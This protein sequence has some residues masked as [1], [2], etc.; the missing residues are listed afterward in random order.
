M[1]QHRTD[2]TPASFR[3]RALPAACLLSLAVGSACGAAG[4]TIRI[5][6][7][8]NQLPA[9]PVS[10]RAPEG[11]DPKAG[12]VLSCAGKEIPA[13]LD[14]DGRLWFWSEGIEAGKS[15][16]CQLTKADRSRIPDRVVLKDAGEGLIEVTIDGKPFTALNFRPTEPRV[17]LYPLLA[18]TGDPVTRDWPMKDNPLEKE[19]K[20]QDHPHHRSM[21][22][23]YGDL[24]VGDFDK[25]GADF[26]AEGEKAGRN[27]QVLRR[28]LGRTDG[29][30]FGRIEAEI[31][32]IAADGTR[33]LVE[34]RAYT[35]FVGNDDM[36][37]IDVRTT[38]R[39]EDQD[40]MFFDT[41]EGGIVSLRLAVTMDETGVT[42][43]ERLR[44]Q[45]CNSNGTVGRACWGQA[46]AWCDYVGTVNGRTLGVAV[47]DHPENFRHP[48][49]W[50][51]RE[52]GLYTAN[53]FGYSYFT[54][55]EKNGTHTFRKGE[56][57]RF[58]H[59]VLIHTGDTRR[60]GIGEQWQLYSRPPEILVADRQ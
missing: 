27:R 43:P 42:V 4:P 52:Y 56:Q 28:V 14:P 25:P 36:R 23:A 16:A 57:V 54:N 10:F 30:V 29:P 13:Q 41:K 26:W 39:F 9:G 5:Q 20:R 55:K 44:G 32:W 46:A 18:S 15:F 48:T 24:R 17:Y 31:D 49:T 47:F 12:C 7:G 60:A 45:M 58:N 37:I 11:L 19:N 50:H 53:P 38:F 6:A 59:R 33:V 22:C 35:F 3:V 51:I 21:W 8:D 1:S 34:S 40:V 2:P